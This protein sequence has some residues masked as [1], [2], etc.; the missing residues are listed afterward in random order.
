MA[1]DT[2]GPKLQ[3]VRVHVIGLDEAHPFVRMSRADLGPR[4]RLG[5]LRRQLLCSIHRSMFGQEK[6]VSSFL[7]SQKFFANLRQSF[8]FSK[9]PML[10]ISCQTSASAK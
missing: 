5:D 1:D 8:E 6:A 3:P 2:R 9:W 7:Q 4:Q 10:A